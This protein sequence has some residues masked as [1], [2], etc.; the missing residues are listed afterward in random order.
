MTAATLQADRRKAEKELQEVAGATFKPEISRL[1]QN[2]W[3]PHECIAAP[4]WQRL[5]KGKHSE[6]ADC[7][8]LLRRIMSVEPVATGLLNPGAPSAVDSIID[9]PVAMLAR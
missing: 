8:M 5:S 9:Q 2:L 4:A 6:H 3:A 1:A 7:W